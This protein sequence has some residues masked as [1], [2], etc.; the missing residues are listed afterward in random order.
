MQP[1][2]LH[3]PLQILNQMNEFR[4]IWQECWV[5]GGRTNVTDGHTNCEME[6][7]YS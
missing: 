4:E 7:T 1:M 5:S 6:V 2:Y 3:P